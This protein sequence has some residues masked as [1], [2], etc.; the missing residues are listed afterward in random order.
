MT[1]K[2]QITSEK[3]IKDSYDQRIRLEKT[4]QSIED[5]EE[6]RS[7]QL[8]IRRDYEQH[9]NQNRLNTGQW[10]RYAKW[11]A[12]TNHEI[13]RARSIYERALQ[14]NVEHI[15]FW[16]SY[17][18][19]EISNGFV[20]HARN[21]LERAIAI[22]PRVDKF[23]YTYIQMEETLHNPAKVRQLFEKWVT[24]GP[25]TRVWDAYVEFEKRWKESDNV[26]N[27]F[28]RYLILNPKG[29]VWLSWINFEIPMG[30]IQYIRNVFESAIDT[31]LLHDMNDDSIP[32][33]IRKWT[34]WELKQGEQKRAKEI[35]QNIL[36]KS[37]FNFHPEQYEKLFNLSLDFRE[38]P[39]SESL[40][41]E[42]NHY[43]KR[44]L[45]YFLNIESNPRDVDS[46]WL[47]LDLL[48]GTE[49][50]EYM[51]LSISRETVPQDNTKTLTW[52]RYI[53]LWIKYAFYQEFVIKDVDRTREI[54]NDCLKVIPSGFTFGKIWILLAEFEIRNS[55][56]GVDKARK[57]L[58]RA[59]GTLK[60]PKNKIFKYYIKL[61]KRLGEYDRVRKIYQKWLELSLTSGKSQS[62][63]IL[64]DFIDFEKELQEYERCESLFYLGLELA[65]NELVSRS[66]NP[67]D[68]LYVSFIEYYKELFE[69]DKARALLKDILK[70]HDDVKLWIFLANFESSIPNEEQL[71]RF[72]ELLSPT[73]EF[74]IEEE[75]KQNS[76]TVF[77]DALKNFTAKQSDEERVIIL[78]AW[79]GYEEK[80]GDSN[81][82][83]KVTEKFPQILKRTRQ[84][85]G[86]HEEYLEYVF[87]ADDNTADKDFSKFLMNAKA[88]AKEEA[89]TK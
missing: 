14:V 33:I 59:I 13:K 6:L 41:K 71:R 11:E 55:D 30:D 15:P 3:L 72:N 25:S 35:F 34:R 7:S 18:N 68:Y 26:R 12:E 20:N 88:W 75:Q 53:Y 37:K 47:L 79:K 21:L 17:I 65:Q 80:Y 22:L 27:V 19:L 64:L 62:V 56:D 84:H 40:Q 36:D 32:T 57:V 82:I 2:E 86:L 69:Y 31:L 58:G 87:P 50:I 45:T 39:A 67:F 70:E 51:E 43:E 29:S 89:S 4:A 10:L 42:E 60:E 52:C 77:E 74:Q 5:L 81:T 24:W 23:W 73:F 78:Q 66:L 48:E 38:Y 28:K 63:E 85:N 76:R 1:T 46:W 8:T 83:A 49:L 61:E 9:I 16:T 44:K 54:W